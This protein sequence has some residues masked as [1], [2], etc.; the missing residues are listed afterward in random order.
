MLHRHTLLSLSFA[1]II[2]NLYAQQTNN[3]PLNLARADAYTMAYNFAP[4]AIITPQ[5]DLTTPLLNPFDYQSAWLNPSVAQDVSG[6]TKPLQL[7][8]QVSGIG[9]MERA[10]FR[11]RGANYYA[12]AQLYHAQ[13]QDYQ[14]GDGSTVKA[15]YKRDGQQ[16]TL[17]YLPNTQ[18]E[19]RIGLVHDNLKDDHQPQHQMDVASTKRFVVNGMARLGE[20]DQSNTFNMQIRHIELD[21]EAN[22]FDLRQAPINPQTKQSQRVS[23]D[24]NRQFTEIQAD[25]RLRYGQHQ[26]VLGIIY[27]DDEHGAK[28]FVHT[29]QGLWRNSYRFPDVHSKH[30][31]LF[32][33][34]HFHL[35]PEQTL[36]LG[37]SYDHLSA[38]ATKRFEA[39]KVGQQTIPAPVSLW[40]AHYGQSVGQ[41]ALGSQKTDGFGAAVHYR[42]QPNEQ[43]QYQIMLDSLIRQPNNVERY[44]ALAGENGAGWLGNPSLQ[45][46]R[47]NRLTLE[48]KWQGEHWLEYGKSQGG[49]Y[50]SAWQIKAKVSYDKAK[51]FIILDRARGQE[52]VV[53]KNGNVVSRAVDATLLAAELETS[54]NINGNLALRGSLRY[55]YGKNNTDHKALYHIRPLSLDVAL[56][57]RDYASFGSYH[58]G[59][60]V[61]HS[62]KHNRRDDDKKQGLGLDLPQHHQAY[63]TVNLYGSVQTKNRVAISFGVQN[64]FNR[65]YY[66]FHEKPH[67]AALNPIPVAAPERTFWLGFH[68]N[69]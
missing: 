28:R 15:G 59:A 38:T 9:H 4:P 63:T 13:L 68:T 54:K 7:H 52:G 21:R 57:W 2:Q 12:I 44:T 42:Y 5:V 33:D 47:H 11:H 22:N 29:P 55:N 32:Y 40:Q 51:D 39:A 17:G 26:S 43:Q 1:L 65:H 6:S 16:L 14:A 49:E 41:S 61:H 37:V 35:N 62:A 24:V 19:Y 45:P 25:Y 3:D 31:H 50:Q 8:A 23:M 67:V 34:H 53:A 48:G 60:S 66:A 46:E 64:L 30:W 20:S 36:S 18:Q 58:L 69:F 27:G 10:L 56:D